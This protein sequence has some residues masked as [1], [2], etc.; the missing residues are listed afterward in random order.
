LFPLLLLYVA[1]FFPD[2]KTRHVVKR[3]VFLGVEL[4]VANDVQEGCSS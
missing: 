3:V 2:I 4:V 1:S